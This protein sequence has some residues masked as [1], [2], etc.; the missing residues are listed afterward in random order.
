MKVKEIIKLC[1]SESWCFHKIR[2]SH[3][4]YKHPKIPGKINIPGSQLSKELKP[5]TKHQIL[6]QIAQT[7]LNLESTA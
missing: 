4:Y 2:G 1:E 5:A 6:K 7:N 3:R